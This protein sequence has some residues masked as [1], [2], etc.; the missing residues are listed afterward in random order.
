MS[1][2]KTLGIRELKLVSDRTKLVDVLMDDR[3]YAEKVLKGGQVINVITREIYT[4]DVAIQGKY[5]VMVGDCSSLIGPTTEVFDMTGKY[6][7][8]GF[9]DSQKLYRGQR[10][11]STCQD[12]LQW[13]SNLIF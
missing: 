12:N 8:P 10:G 13:K 9:I 5:I 2:E 6:I 7:S 3:Q 4:A 1:C 11:P